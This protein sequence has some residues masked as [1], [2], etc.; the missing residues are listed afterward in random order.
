MK[1]RGFIVFAAIIVLTACTRPGVE[2]ELLKSSDLERVVLVGGSLISTM[3]DYGFFE[4]SLI[5]HFQSDHV[6]IRN[7]A[8]PADDVFGL[9]RS[10]F[11]SAQNTQSWQPPNAEEGFGSKVLMD[12]I[13]EA[14]PKAILIGYGPEVAFY[15]TDE[16]FDLFKSGYERLL[17][18]AEEQ[19]Q[20]LFSFPQVS[21]KELTLQLINMKAEIK[22]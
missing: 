16:E 3:E 6:S 10:Q 1:I 13:Q 2:K 14:A 5:R 4:Y 18:F 17:T 15:E 9:A 21:K 11:G 7:V 12:H 19:C 20:R 8:W 22:I